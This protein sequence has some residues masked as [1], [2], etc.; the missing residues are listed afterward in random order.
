M[1]CRGGKLSRYILKLPTDPTWSA[2]DY[3][4]AAALEARW[5][6]LGV[7]EEERKR[8]IP[9]AVWRA[10]Y[11]ATQYPAAILARLDELVVL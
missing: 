5:K 4:R 2:E 6:C 1:L 9:C 7:C 10:K 8:L 3:G 11:P